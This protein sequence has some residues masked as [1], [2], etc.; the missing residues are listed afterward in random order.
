MI[1]CAEAV[2]LLW[3]YLDETV[4]GEDRALVEQH[5]GRCRACCGELEFAQELRALLARPET[6]RLPEDVLHRLHRT[7]EELGR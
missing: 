2:R 4:E 1:A 7:I 5:L 6:D 3:E